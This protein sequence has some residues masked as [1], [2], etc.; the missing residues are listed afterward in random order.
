MFLIMCA[1]I[2]IGIVG[3][4]GE[5]ELQHVGRLRLDAHQVPHVQLSK[6]GGEGQRE[7]RISTHIKR[8]RETEMK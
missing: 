2:T 5:A 7:V 3:L 8:Q 6:G 1:A 4:E